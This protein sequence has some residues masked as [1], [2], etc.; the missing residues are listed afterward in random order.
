MRSLTDRINKQLELKQLNQ[1]K[2]KEMLDTADIDADLQWSEQQNEQRA[3]IDAM[4]DQ[5][6]THNAEAGIIR[7]KFGALRKQID[8]FISNQ[9]QNTQTIQALQR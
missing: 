6:Q 2:Y 7:N 5:I 9:Q 4:I 3:Q 8:Q 1:Q